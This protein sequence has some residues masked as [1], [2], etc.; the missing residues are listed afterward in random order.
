MPYAS[1]RFNWYDNSAI[2]QNVIDTTSTDP[3][4]PLCLVCVASDKGPEQLRTVYGDA[5]YKL[6]GDNIQFSRYGQPLLQAARIIDAGGRLMIKRVVA[7]DATLANAVI[8]ANL[9]VVSVQKVNG[10]GNPLYIDP[11]TGNET[12]VVSETKAMESN[13]VVWYES[14]SITDSTDMKSVVEGAKL[15]ADVAGTEDEDGNLVYKYPIFVVTDNG[16]GTSEKRFRIVPDYISSKNQDF[17]I[18]NFSVYYDDENSSESCYFTPD[19]DLIYADMSMSLDAAVKR[20]LLQVNAKVLPEYINEFV[21]T[22]SDAIGLTFDELLYQDFLFGKTRKNKNLEGV[23]INPIDIEGTVSLSDEYGINLEE[24]SNGAF[25]DTPIKTPEY[26][27]KVIEFFNGTFTPDIYNRD[28]YRIDCCF[29]ANYSESIKREIE[30]LVDWREDLFYFRDLGILTNSDDIVDAHN[31]ATKS[32]F[33]ASYAT[34]YDV[35]D[36]YSKKQISVTCMYSLCEIIVKRF[37]LSA[38]HLPFAG[39]ANGFVIEDAIPNTINFYPVVTP[40]IDQK[41]LFDEE[42]INYADYVDGALTVQ[43]LYTSQEPYTQLSFINNVVAIQEVAKAVRAKAPISRF[44]LM[45]QESLN[46]YQAFVQD[47]LDGYKDNFAELEFVYI[48]DDIMKANK[49]FKASISFRFND[50]VQ[51]EIFDLYALS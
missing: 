20:D 51:A 47:I 37:L 4:I 14:F 46:K 36:P 7:D 29:D 1:T 44:T 11:V 39:M 43:S 24:G 31:R 42:R 38:R 15:L 17:M 35:M 41:E 28:N 8:V 18:Y 21:T 34:S 9:K 48:Q 50:F 5:F 22:Y 10:E 2:P 25:G 6:Y 27:T 26:E 45:D 23:T 16:R 3:N 12:T 32:K 30:K 40:F 19:D 13:A 49:I 33:S